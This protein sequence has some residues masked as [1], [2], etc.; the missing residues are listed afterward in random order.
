MPYIC[1]CV[2]I[3]IFRHFLVIL[4]FFVVA[5]AAFFYCCILFLILLVLPNY[6]FSLLVYLNVSVIYKP[7]SNNDL[8]VYKKT[9]K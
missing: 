1:V 5:A 9:N 3:F 8:N 4:V 2:L 7:T 6:I